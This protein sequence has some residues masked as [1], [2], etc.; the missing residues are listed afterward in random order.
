MHEEEHDFDLVDLEASEEHENLDIIIKDQYSQIKYLQD[1]LERANFITSF[2]EQENNQLKAKQLSLE[3]SQFEA[4]MHDVKGKSVADSE[5]SK[6][7][8]E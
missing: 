1:N 8:E 5:E 3:K 4:S 6:N 7:H 2:L